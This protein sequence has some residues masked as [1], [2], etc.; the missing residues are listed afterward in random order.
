MQQVVGLL[1]QRRFQISAVERL[2]IRI[3]MGIA[4]LRFG[5]HLPQQRPAGGGKLLVAVDGLSAAVDAG[6]VFTVDAGGRFCYDIP[7]Q[8]GNRHECISFSGP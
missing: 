7:R 6:P 4:D 1:A 5:V 2:D 3:L 8:E